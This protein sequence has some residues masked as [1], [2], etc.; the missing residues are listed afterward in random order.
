MK[1]LYGYFRPLRGRIGLELFIKTVATLMDL[2]IPWILG[3]IIDVVIP[4]RSTGLI[5][6]WGTMMIV[7]SVV[8]VTG[9][10]YAN[11]LASS[12]ARDTTES[13]R[14]DLFS[15]IMALSSVRTDSFTAASL[16][17]RI[18]DDTYNINNMTGRLLRLGIRAPILLVGGMA[19]TLSMDAPLALVWIAVLPIA[20]GIFIA[21]SLRGIPM[22]SRLQ[23]SVDRMVQVIRENI[24]GVR[25]I[26]ALSRTEYEKR[27]FSQINNEVSANEE[28]ANISMGLTNPAINML[29]NIALSLVIFVGAY[30]VNSGRT[31]VGTIVAFTSYFAVI[32]NAVLGITRIFVTVSRAAASA[33]RVGEVLYDEADLLREES[34]ETARAFVRFRDVGFSY[35]KNRENLSDISFEL[36]RGETL[37]I[38]G[39]TGSGKTTL[40]NLL[41]RFYDA[42]RGAVLIDGRDV[43]TY[44]SG[45]LRGKFGVVFQNDMLFADSIRSNIDFGRNLPEEDINLALECAQATDFVSRLPKGI[46]T[47]LNPK[48]NDLSG[49]QKQRLLIARALAAKPEILVL[50][51]SSSALDYGTDAALREALRTSYAG[52]TVITVAQRISSVKDMDKIIFLDNGKIVGLGTHDRLMESCEMYRETAELQMGRDINAAE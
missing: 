32:L 26:K 24:S 49:G 1:W 13:I 50:D 29:L 9:N 31:G 46:D 2:C 43:R 34:D 36:N 45:E 18:T 44:D 40:I 33:K 48:G 7:C 37:G 20:I 42:D 35:N 6:V 5:A 38:I 23:S 47:V 28:R 52:S 39:P 12:I 25:V 11:R 15:K 51:D 19:I 3:H 16:V 14:H 17:S 30:R 21:V 8:C 10:I 27:R 22:F 41:M 4:S